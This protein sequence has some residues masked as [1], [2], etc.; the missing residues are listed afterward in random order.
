MSATTSETRSIRA[1]RHPWTIEV[2]TEDQ[3]ERVHAATLRVLEQVGLQVRSERVLREL[4]GA[5][6]EVDEATM[7]ARF[8]SAMVD[9]CMAIL[10]PRLLIV[11]RQPALAHPLAGR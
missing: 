11:G 4:A 5:G 8:P 2:L 9:E 1:L 10:P 6:A 3:L 7:R